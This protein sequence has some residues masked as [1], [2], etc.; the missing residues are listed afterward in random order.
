MFEKNV[1][2]R[3]KDASNDGHRPPLIPAV[4]PIPSHSISHAIP[5]HPL[6]N[7]DQNAGGGTHSQLGA[8]FSVMMMMSCAI[9][10]GELDVAK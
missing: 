2:H 7:V 10:D 1:K 6:Q 8:D 9:S 3:A 4:Y 5:M